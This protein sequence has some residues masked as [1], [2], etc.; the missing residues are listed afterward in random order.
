[1]NENTCLLNKNCHRILIA[2]RLLKANRSEYTAVIPYRMATSTRAHRK[3]RRSEW[4]T[5]CLRTLGPNTAAV[6]AVL[7]STFPC[8]H[9]NDETTVNNSSKTNRSDKTTTQ[10]P[11]QK[12]GLVTAFVRPALVIWK[13]IYR[14]LQVPIHIVHQLGIGCTSA[15]D[16]HVSVVAHRKRNSSTRLT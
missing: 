8:L 16:V 6:A 13:A 15:A 4:Y 10:T 7:M 1:M 5:K 9:T 12:L 11:S 14:C 3:Y 2:T